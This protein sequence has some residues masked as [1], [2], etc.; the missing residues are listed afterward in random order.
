MQKYIGIHT[1][2]C[3][4]HMYLYVHVTRCLSCVYIHTHIGAHVSPCI[5]IYRPD[6]YLLYKNKQP[7]TDRERRTNPKKEINNNG[8]K[9]GKQERQIEKG[10][11]IDVHELTLEGPQH[12]SLGLASM[13]IYI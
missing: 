6:I 11:E 8:M 2:A 9:D 10:R 12:T 4:C 1:H 3:T 7:K 5:Y 13:H